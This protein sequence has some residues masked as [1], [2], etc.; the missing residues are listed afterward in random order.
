MPD[1]RLEIILAAKDLTGNAFDHVQGR[2]MALERRVLSI[3]GILGG[4][5]LG[6]GAAQLAGHIEHTAESFEQLEAQLDILYKGRGRQVLEEINAWALDMPVNTQKAVAA[7]VQMKALGLDPTLDRLQTLTDVATIFGEDVLSR[8]T[9]QLGQM[10]AKG[11]VMAQDLNVMA[12]A[13]VNARKYIMDAF[14]MTVDEIQ[15]SGIDVEKV[16]EA[17]FKGMER[18]FGGSAQRMMSSWRGLKET[19]ASYFV[20]IERKVMD[21]GLF[22]A[23]KKGLSDFNGEMKNW[24]AQ[25]D[26]LLKQKVP[27][28]TSQVIE[29]V[30][31]LAATTATVVGVYSAIPDEITGAAGDGIIGRV[32]FGGWGPAKIIAGIALINNALSDYGMGLGDLKRKNDEAGRAVVEFGVS[33]YEVLSGQRN[34]W[35]GEYTEWKRAAESAS[36]FWQRHKKAAE[37]YQSDIQR[38]LQSD[39]LNDFFGRQKNQM[40]YYGSPAAKIIRQ[41]NADQAKAAKDAEAA[42]KNAAEE[43]E[44]SQ[45]AVADA[46]ADAQRKVWEQLDKELSQNTEAGRFRG[47][48]QYL[49]DLKRIRAEAAKVYGEAG[50]IPETPK[51]REEWEQY[52]TPGEDWISRHRE[53]I[54]PYD[55]DLVKQNLEEISRQGREASDEWV[56]LSQRTAEAMQGNFSDLFFDAFTG[57]LKSLEDY[58]AAIFESIQRAAADMAGQLATEA[59]FGGRSVG[60][61]AGGGGLIAMLAGLFGG[62]GSSSAMSASTALAL[63]RHAGGEVDGSGPSRRIPAWIL[64]AAPRLHDGLAPDEYPAILQRGERVLSR[65]EASM[66]AANITI[67][68]PAP[69]GRMDRESLSQVGHAAYSGLRRAWARNA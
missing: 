1:S 23:M 27:E 46:V 22:D 2:L 59:I 55:A 66:P 10:S 36:D 51:R 39:P 57:K 21:A 35:T 45:K 7:W 38:L 18:D 58:A 12:E 30:K 16:I 15:N 29:S 31:G 61:T 25:N 33:F 64:A 43:I 52:P 68:V 44:R 62:S 48:S 5:G 60:G 69:G 3:G 24:L 37:E 40:G 56:Q 34:W 47:L 4:F 14:G 20:E 42:A 53:E 6:F 13:G 32:V 65:D 50:V 63:V 28:Y 54:G 26:A 8:L 41:I 11:K 9:L 67:I 19:A 17:I 49:A